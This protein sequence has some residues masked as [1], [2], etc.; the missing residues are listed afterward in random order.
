MRKVFSIMILLGFV[1]LL[2]TGCG[3][4]GMDGSWDCVEAEITASSAAI[5]A[6]R[7]LEQNGAIGSF[8]Q[9]E[10]KDG[11]VVKYIEDVTEYKVSTVKQSDSVI[12]AK[13][14]DKYGISYTVELKLT[15][16]GNR[17]IATRDR[18]RYTLERADFFNKV[19]LGMVKKIPVWAYIV[20]GVLLVGSIALRTSSSRKNSAGRP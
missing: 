8:C 18:N 6:Y 13:V 3:E 1:L 20:A 7:T 14:T 17:I 12:T 15:D 11:E 16:D 10:I 19:I 9:V 4:K 2:L 5:S